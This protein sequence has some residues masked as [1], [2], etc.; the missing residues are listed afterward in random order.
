MRARDHAASLD[1]SPPRRAN[2][3]FRDRHQRAAV[4][5]VLLGRAGLDG[6]WSEDGPV[7]RSLRNACDPGFPPG[8]LP[9]LMLCFAIWDETAILAFSDVFRLRNAELEAVGELL[10][11]VARGPGEVDRWIDRWSVGASALPPS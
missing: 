9:V 7:M 3:T 4:C 8:T 5:R 1:T 2:A 11:C 10:T 6:A